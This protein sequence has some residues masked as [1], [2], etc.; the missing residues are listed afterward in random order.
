MARLIRAL[1]DI[2]TGDAVALISRKTG[3]SITPLDVGTTRVVTADI[4][5]LGALVNFDAIAPVII[6]I[7]IPIGTDACNRIVYHNTLCVRIAIERF[8]RDVEYALRTVAV[9]IEVTGWAFAKSLALVD[10]TVRHRVTNREIA[11]IG[12]KRS[13]AVGILI[14]VGTRTTIT[15]RVIGARCY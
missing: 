1:I 11:Q 5:L 9:G 15:S 13:V 7:S 12:A 4:D 14:A 10:S 3:A 2:R 8:A 6:N